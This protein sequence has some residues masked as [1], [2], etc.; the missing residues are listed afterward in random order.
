LN[1]PVSIAWLGLVALVAAN[2]AACDDRRPVGLVTVEEAL[3]RS[4][5]PLGVC[6]ARTLTINQHGRLMLLNQRGELRV[7]QGTGAFEVLLE[8]V[9]AIAHRTSGGL[10]ANLENGQ[11]LFLDEDHQQQ[12]IYTPGE[13]SPPVTII[14]NWA[15]APETGPWS[16]V[17]DTVIRQDSGFD[18]SSGHSTVLEHRREIV[19]LEPFDGGAIR[20]AARVELPIDR[21][22]SLLPGDAGALTRH[23]EGELQVFVH[24]NRAGAHR[25]GQRSYSPLDVTVDTLWRGMAVSTDG[26]TGLVEMI[27]YGQSA[28]FQQIAVFSGDG[29]QTVLE[30]SAQ[31]AI[32]PLWSATGEMVGFTTADPWIQFVG[33]DGNDHAFDQVSTWLDNAELRVEGQSFAA[34]DGPILIAGHQNGRRVISRLLLDADEVA[35]DRIAA[36]GGAPTLE[37]RS[38]QPTEDVS[39]THYVSAPSNEAMN[40]PLANLVIVD[41]HGG[42]S[43]RYVPSSYAHHAALLNDGATIYAVNYRGSSGFGRIVEGIDPPYWTVSDM[44]SDISDV[45]SIAKRDNPGRTIFVT[46]DSF[47]GYLALAYAADPFAFEAVDGVVVYGAFSGFGEGMAHLERLFGAHN[48]HSILIRSDD[49]SDSF[50]QAISGSDTIGLMSPI[51]LLHGTA[52]ERAPVHLT[53]RVAGA[54]SNRGTRSVQW[55]LVERA[56][57][58]IEPLALLDAVHSLNRSMSDDSELTSDRPQ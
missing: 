5:D 2:L 48:L 3:D 51:V 13:V 17:E 14:G 42:P 21:E 45:V 49:V 22:L 47:G 7:E 34:P 20:E 43:S 57:H 10:I 28:T 52:D 26:A 30:S 24:H 56:G 58:A 41:V 38:T 19:F 23:I 1:T 25:V 12:W 50:D 33:L 55:R 9:V 6:T 53:Q 31:Q 36:C 18:G 39:L 29:M 46:G 44:L 16:Y 27:G 11:F 15:L 8:N 37:I 40:G 4:A 35:E 54:L 32:A